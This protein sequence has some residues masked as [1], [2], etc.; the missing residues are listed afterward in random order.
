MLLAVDIGNSHTVCGVFRDKRLLYHWRLTSDRRR[1]AD[2]LAARYQ[3]LFSLAGLSFKEIGNVIIAGVVPSLQTTWKDFAEK[4]LQAAPLLVDGRTPD[5]GIRIKI[6]YPAEVGA[7][8][9]VNAVAAYAEYGGDL[10]VVDFGT[11]ITFDCISDAGEYLGGTI[12]PGL[13]ISLDALAR[14]TAKLPRIDIAVPPPGVR[15]GNTVDAIKAGMLYG[16]GALVD[17]LVGRLKETFAP[18]ARPAAVKVIATGGLAGLIAPYA[19]TIDTVNPM[20]TLEGLRLIH[21]RN[22]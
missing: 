2:E 1:T 7:D 16:Y 8:R 18:P 12:V 19:R 10:I 9:I 13:I 20:L 3:P 14:R 4:Y 5:T 22:Q 17:G 21:E 11:A 15:G 6:D